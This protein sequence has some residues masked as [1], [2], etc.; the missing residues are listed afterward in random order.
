MAH[1]AYSDDKDGVRH[2]TALLVPP[3]Y[4]I[5]ATLPHLYFLDF[6]RRL[7]TP[8][9]RHRCFQTHTKS[10][11]CCTCYVYF[12]AITTFTPSVVVASWSLNHYLLP[13][14][15]TLPK[16]VQCTTYAQPTSPPYPRSATNAYQEELL[17]WMYF[18]SLRSA[19][20]RKIT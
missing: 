2:H 4:I 18:I 8:P 7:P 13:V 17:S 10:R 12:T 9:H 20:I 11:C 5:G 3:G 19:Y 15:T 1:S 6:R 16:H 14:Y